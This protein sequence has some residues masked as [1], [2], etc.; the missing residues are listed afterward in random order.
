MLES[1]SIYAPLYNWLVGQP[2]TV[3]D[4]ACTFEEIE[5][6]LGF[7]LPETARRK[8]QWWENNSTR[9][10]QAKAWLEAGFLTQDVNVVRRTLAFHRNP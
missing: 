10:V 2:V 3:N 1:T 4:M 8:Q 6:V 9:H 5:S 7:T